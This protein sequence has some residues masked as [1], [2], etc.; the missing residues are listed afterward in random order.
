MNVMRGMMGGSRQP[1]P[2]A[3]AD[4]KLVFKPDQTYND[5]AKFMPNGLMPHEFEWSLSLKDIDEESMGPGKSIRS[6][7]YT[8]GNFRFAILAFPQGTSKE[9]NI[10]AGD[11][12]PTLAAFIEAN[13]LETL[14]Q[15]RWM[16]SGV[17]YSVQ[18]LNQKDYSKTI[19]KDDVW[20]FSKREVDRGWHSFVEEPNEF[21]DPEYGWI[22]D[23]GDMRV[24]FRTQIY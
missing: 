21:F 22:S 14:D 11:K 3:G 18:L 16:F 6:P 8:I 9:P 15:E 4:D 1:S 13:P 19:W 5:L 2:P 10:K 7:L 23:D 17:R 24:I 20:S 12:Y